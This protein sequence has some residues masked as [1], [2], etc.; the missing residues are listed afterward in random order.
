MSEGLLNLWYLGLSTANYPYRGV[1]GKPSSGSIEVWEESY[2]CESNS[3]R[4]RRIWWTVWK[5]LVEYER[6][7][8]DEGLS[9]RTPIFRIKI[10]E[11]NGNDQ[12]YG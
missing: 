6:N 11:V 9:D 5:D 2:S 1:I 8:I 12:G 3:F 10:E 4:G 7:V